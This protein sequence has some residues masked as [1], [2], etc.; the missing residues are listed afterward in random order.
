MMEI[1]GTQ[2]GKQSILCCCIILAFELR[3]SG[4]VI[5]VRCAAS[6]RLDDGRIHWA[7]HNPDRLPMP[8]IPKPITKIGIK[9]NKYLPL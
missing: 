6:D 4:Q 2:L 9:Y 5:Q 3:D 1:N 8:S 7:C